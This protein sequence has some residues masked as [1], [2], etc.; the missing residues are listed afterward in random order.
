MTLKCSNHSLINVLY[1]RKGCLKYYGSSFLLTFF[2][3]KE[4]EHECNFLYVKRKSNTIQ[5]AEFSL[6]FSNNLYMYNRDLHPCLLEFKIL[7]ILQ[8]VKKLVGYKKILYNLCPLPFQYTPHAYPKVNKIGNAI[9]YFI[10]LL[11]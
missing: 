7:N 3:I 10:K 11:P 4:K 9:M 2:S 5:S 8:F 1:Q 6:I